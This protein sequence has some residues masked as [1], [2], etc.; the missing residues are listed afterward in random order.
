MDTL[1]NNTA[2]TDETVVFNDY[3][4]SLKRFQHTSDSYATTQVYIFADLRTASNGC[5]GIYH[6]PGI[7]VSADI[8][9]GWHHDYT[10]GH[11][12]AVSGN[13]MWYNAHTFFSV[14]GLQRNFIMKLERSHLYGFHFLD[15]KVHHYCFLHPFV[16][17]PAVWCW[18]CY[19]QLT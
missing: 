7:Y 5:P 12:A 3:R 13:R 9:I 14:V 10:T 8:Y 17:S 11:V 4:C 19:A 15:G 18:F 2:G 6:S 16:Y 1:H